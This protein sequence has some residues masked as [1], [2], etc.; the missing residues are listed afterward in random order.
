MVGVVGLSNLL[1]WTLSRHT[2]LTLG[3][4]MGLITGSVL[5]LWP[6]QEGVEPELGSTVKGVV[7]TAETLATIDPEDWPLAWF[8]PSAVQIGASL[9]LIAVGYGATWLIARLGG[10]E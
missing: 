4:L 10:K 1:K 2:Q 7:V 9:A 6:F 5:G 8:T 3:F